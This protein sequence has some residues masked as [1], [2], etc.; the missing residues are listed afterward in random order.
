MIAPVAASIPH[1]NTSSKLMMDT[2]L[3]VLSMIIVSVLYEGASAFTTV[4]SKPRLILV[5]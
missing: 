1:A 5:V 4:S 3:K 2:A